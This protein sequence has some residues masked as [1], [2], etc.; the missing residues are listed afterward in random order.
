VADD[1][2]EPG[3]GHQQH[4]VGDHI[5]GDDELQA[6]PGRVQAGMD[7]GGGDVDHG[8][9]QQRHE[10]AGQDDGEDPARAGRTPLGRARRAGGGEGVGHGTEPAALWIQVPGA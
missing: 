8:G 10:L 6:G 7:G 1:V 9:V 4:G 3:A 5:A 2:A